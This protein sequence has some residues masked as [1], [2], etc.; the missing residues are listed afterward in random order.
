MSVLHGRRLPL[1]VLVVSLAA[2][3][4]SVVWA[5]GGLV[6]R[7]G[8]ATMMGTAISSGERVRGM[9]DTRSGDRP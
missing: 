8:P 6:G 1:V 4:A 7:S 3:I 9:A 5:A 2:L